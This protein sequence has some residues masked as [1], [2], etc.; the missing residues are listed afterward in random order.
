MF[1]SLAIT[2][3]FLLIGNVVFRHFD[4]QLRWRRVLKAV[5]G[6][7]VT[8]LAWHYFGRT[9]VIVWFVIVATP[10]IYVHGLWLPRHGVNGWTGEPREKYCALR[11]W[12]LPQR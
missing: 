5:A 10:L 11:G 4:P 8:A 9:S 12:S 6:L 2:G 1:V 7:A 3:V